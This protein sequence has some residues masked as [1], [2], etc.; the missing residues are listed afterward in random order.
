MLL[1]QTALHQQVERIGLA[2]QALVDQRIG[3]GIL[4]HAAHGGQTLK[5]IIENE[6]F[7]G[8]HGVSIALVIRVPA[9]GR[10]C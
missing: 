8:S 3:L 4:G 1:Q 2:G 6:L 10:L 9:R 5:K 7:L